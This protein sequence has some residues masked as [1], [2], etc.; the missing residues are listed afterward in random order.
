MSNIR[1]RGLA[2]SWEK[3]SA[4]IHPPP[5]IHPMETMPCCLP[6]ALPQGFWTILAEHAEEWLWR[7]SGMRMLYSSAITVCLCKSGLWWY[8]PHVREISAKFCVLEYH[9]VSGLGLWDRQKL[10]CECWP[11]ADNCLCMSGCRWMSKTELLCSQARDRCLLTTT[12]K[13]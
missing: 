13:G 2:E 11:A 5:Q 6:S 7:R 10:S 9:A 4:G 1:E 8:E 12:N 3:T